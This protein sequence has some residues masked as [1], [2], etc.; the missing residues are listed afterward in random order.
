MEL[1]KDF[2]LEEYDTICRNDFHAF[3][4]RVFHIISPGDTFEDNWHIHFMCAVLQDA[5]EKGEGRIIINVPPGSTKSITASV[6]W[7]AW[8]LGK[9]A[10]RRIVAASHTEDL[11]TTLNVACRDLINSELYQRIFPGT[12]IRSDQSEKKSFGT[13]RGGLR[14]CFGVNTRIT[15]QGGRVLI[16]DDPHDTQGV[17]S[18]VEREKTIKWFNNSFYGRMRSDKSIIVII[19]QRQHPLDLTGW[20]LE[21]SPEKWTQIAIEE[22]ASQNYRISFAGRTIERKKGELLRPRQ[23][24][25]EWVKNRMI[26][27]GPYSWA[28]QHQQDPVPDGGRVFL[29]TWLRHWST[30]PNY[31]RMTRYVFVDP[32]LGKKDASILNLD[33]TCMWVIGLGEDGN[34]YVLDILRDHLNL[35]Q[36][37][38]RLFD[39][40]QKWE[41]H[42]VFYERYG[43]Q[44]DIDYIDEKQSEWNYRFKISEIGGKLK[45]EDRIERLQPIFAEGKIWLPPYGF[46][47]KMEDGRTIDLVKTFVD[48]EYSSFPS[49]RHDD[50]LD[51]LARIMDVSVRWPKPAQARTHKKK[52]TTGSWM[53]V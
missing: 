39:L 10:T 16:V 30:P 23:F 37:A 9:D 33:Y 20:I 17:E 50:M 51:A 3:L 8:V 7:P 4:Q 29:M 14:K 45:K 38:A 21:N 22:I 48:E 53:S 40:V 26:T 18:Q 42:E 36:R 1:G 32:S 34:Y 41:V 6:A 11:A 35:Q 52:K 5:Y 15:G 49:C 24:G 25:P 28:A 12:T 46:F 43:M 2:S 47:V 44:S 13:T 31:K 19:M 27:L